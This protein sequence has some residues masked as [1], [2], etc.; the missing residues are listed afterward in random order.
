M[1]RPAVSIILSE[2][3]RRE[4]AGLARRRKTAQGLARRARIV[5]AA[6]E[7]LDNKMIVARLGADANTVGKWRRRFSERRLDGLYDDPRSGA[8]RKIGD[9]QIA[10]VI[11]RTLEETPPDGTHWSLRSMARAVGYAPSTIHR[12]WQAFG[13]QPHRS[14][15][16]KLSSDPLFVEKVRDIVGLYL[17]PP[18]R[19]LVLCVD[20]KSQI[21]ALDRS[22]PLLPMRPGQVERRTHDYVRHGT[23]TLFAALDTATGKVIGQCF[24][25]HRA[26]E[27]LAFLRT[28]ETRVPD[29]LDVHLV[30][31]NYAT[32]K[33]PAVQRWLPASPLACPLHADR[34]LLA[35]P[36]RALLRPPDRKTTAARGPSFDR[37]TR[38]RHLPLH[39][40]RQ[41]KPATLPMDQGRRRHPRH[42]QTVLPAHS[43]NCRAP[44]HHHQNFR[45]RTLGQR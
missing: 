1:G 10:E 7:G 43:R 31:D 30:M 28:L 32:H 13:L 39:R 4:L 6:A 36:G 22:R 15:T 18:E 21:Q 41:R 35:E 27:F 37:G 33:T 40:H 3:E 45:I 14:E 25:R 2:A 29:N 12:I 38:T 19:A 44:K 34:R 9:E 23:T 17:S 42:H 5:L 20:E 8:P 16:F 24:P 11:G 26:R